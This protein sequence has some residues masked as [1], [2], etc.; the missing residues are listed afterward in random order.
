MGV[1]IIVFLL[2]CL[3][4]LMTASSSSVGVLEVEDTR[5]VGISVLGENGENIPSGMFS[6]MD[7][8]GS[9]YTAEGGDAQK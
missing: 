5:S 8:R 3:F 2:V 4:Q 9:D 7:P 6:P 1:R